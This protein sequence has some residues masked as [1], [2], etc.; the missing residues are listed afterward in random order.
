M[1]QTRDTV[2]QD[3]HSLQTSASVLVSVRGSQSELGSRAPNSL[4]GDAWTD[5]SQG[6]DSVT[7]S[8]GIRRVQRNSVGV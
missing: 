1:S 6:V 7:C 5:S 8:Q 2:S 3:G 4:G